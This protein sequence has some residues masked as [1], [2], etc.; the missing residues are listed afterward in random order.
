L[1]DA[2]KAKQFKQFFSV[3]DVFFAN[4]PYTI[5]IKQEKYYQ[6]L[7]YLI[8]KMLG[9][10]IDVEVSTN[11]GRIDAVM[12]LA[13]Q[14]FLFEFKLDGSADDA[15]QQIKDNHYYQ[16]YQLSAKP[17]TLIGANFDSKERRVTDWKTEALVT[18]TG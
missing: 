13:D 2:L 3:L 7:F 4:V 10:R 14:V 5:H 9:L 11:E 16:K 18:T 1:L 6:S 17:I 8:F 12:I 15:L